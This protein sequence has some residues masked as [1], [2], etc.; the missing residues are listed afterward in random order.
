MPQ[1]YSG[2]FVNGQAEVLF[3]MALSVTYSKQWCACSICKVTANYIKHINYDYTGEG[4][5][6]A[7]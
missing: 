6:L 3:D 7:M 5:G 1:Q 2:L 4:E